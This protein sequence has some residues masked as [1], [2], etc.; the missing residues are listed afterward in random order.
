MTFSLRRK[1]SYL[2]IDI[3][4]TAIKI[5]ELKDIGRKS[6]LITYG[7]VNLVSDINHLSDKDEIRLV[8]VLKYTLQQIKSSSQK[9]VTALPNSSVFSSIVSLP[10]MS[11]KD[12]KK[13]IKW[14]AKKFVPMPIEEMI[15]DWQVLEESRNISSPVTQTSPSTQK[16]L[17]I[18]KVAKKENNRSAV[19]ILLT[20]A[21]RKLIELYIQI[22]KQANLEL[23]GIETESFALERSLVGFDPSPIMIVDISAFNT[24]IVIVEKGIPVLTRT[25]DIGGE[26]VTDAIAANLRIDRQRAEQFKRDVGFTD[27]G[28]SAI[29]KIIE[30]TLSPII[31]DVKYAFDLYQL[32]EGAV[33]V[34][35]II[36]TGG[37]AFLPALDSYL[38]KLL[39]IKVYIGDPWSRVSYPEELRPALEEISAR[40]AV[41]VGLAMREIVS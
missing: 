33:D 9:C 22:F 7:Y 18:L 5:V 25:V 10:K 37:S 6:K 16:T 11:E 1:I 4:R 38:S 14:E 13:A 35:K 20:A 32:R 12:L 31:N 41:A 39:N 8:K 15:L 28:G 26:A 27:S 17:K 29:S 24:D 40:F 19:K 21:P 23:L 30:S 2:G 34:E 36:L 3:G